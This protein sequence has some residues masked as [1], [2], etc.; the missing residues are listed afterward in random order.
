MTDL[1]MVFLLTRTVKKTFGTNARIRVY[2]DVGYEYSVIFKYV[3]NV[4]IRSINLGSK[5]SI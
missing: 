4:L 5:D 1:R 2:L 3:I